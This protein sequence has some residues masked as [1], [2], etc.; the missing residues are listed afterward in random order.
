M[1]DT[2]CLLIALTLNL[3]SVSSVVWTVLVVS[4]ID[5]SPQN[6]TDSFFGGSFRSTIARSCDSHSLGSSVFVDKVFT[7]N[8]NA[9]S[10]TETTSHE[11][12]LVLLEDVWKQQ[13]QESITAHPYTP[14]HIPTHHTSL[15]TTHPYTPHI[16][17]PRSLENYLSVEDW[18]LLQTI[19]PKD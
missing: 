13:C 9:F 8:F 5:D 2:A 7:S 10:F 16:T 17:L 3:L 11:T 18:C 19:C 4:V 14:P 1:L 6:S 12:V 15:Y